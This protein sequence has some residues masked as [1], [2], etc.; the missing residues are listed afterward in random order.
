MNKI[1]YEQ[2]KMYEHESILVRVKRTIYEV[3]KYS[4]GYNLSFEI[5]WV[6]NLE[7]CSTG[8]LKQIVQLGRKELWIA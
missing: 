5:T 1:C 8:A 7:S 3:E 6:I 2:E 4:N